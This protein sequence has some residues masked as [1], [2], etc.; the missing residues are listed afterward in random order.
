MKFSGVYTV[1]FWVSIASKNVQAHYANLSRL[2]KIQFVLLS[3]AKLGQKSLNH[4][5]ST[6]KKPLPALAVRLGLVLE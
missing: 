1:H 5:T 3:E 2:K 6:F 4:S